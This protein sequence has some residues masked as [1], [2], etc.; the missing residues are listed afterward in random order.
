M[1]VTGTFDEIFFTFLSRKIRSLTDSGLLGLVEE[2]LDDLVTLVSFDGN[3][4]DSVE[5][6]D[7]L[8]D[9]TH[10]KDV[11]TYFGSVVLTLLHLHLHTYSIVCNDLW[12]E[13]ARHCIMNNAKTEI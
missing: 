2:F 10:E 1:G 5:F 6:E 4:D 3:E 11:L 12:R 9:L 8:D 13:V 7:D